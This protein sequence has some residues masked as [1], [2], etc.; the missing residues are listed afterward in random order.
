M[1]LHKID[2]IDFSINQ[3][4][5]SDRQLNLVWKKGELYLSMKNI[6]LTDGEIW[7]DIPLKDLENIQI[8]SE[9]PT[10]L[11]FQLPSLEVIVTGNY[12]ERLLAL[13]HLLLPYLHP[14]R[15]ELMKD[16]LKT[17]IKF[18]SLGVRNPIALTTLVPLTTD[19]IRTLIISAKEDELIT[20][21]GGLTDKAYEIFS[22]EERDLLR[23]LEE[24]NG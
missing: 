6:M 14:K 12:A 20:P 7:F 16:S 24:T 22:S 23:R 2:D 21:E 13:R 17:L 11:R 10:K 5:A 19:E 8:V 1:Q 9:N 18:W 15:E 4:L 3:G